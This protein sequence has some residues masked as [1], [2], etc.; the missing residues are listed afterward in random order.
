L[1]LERTREREPLLAARALA[2]ILRYFEQVLEKAW[3]HCP[4]SQIFFAG[5]QAHFALACCS[6]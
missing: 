4:L 3:H 6:V 1:A 2:S 5:P